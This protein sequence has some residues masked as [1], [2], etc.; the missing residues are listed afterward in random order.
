MI[1]LLVIFFILKEFIFVLC[2][3]LQ[4]K[5]VAAM[6]YHIHINFIGLIFTG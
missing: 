1:V 4:L 2:F 5:Y 6:H 3:L